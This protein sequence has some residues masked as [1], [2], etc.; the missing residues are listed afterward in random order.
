M[1]CKNPIREMPKKDRIIIGAYG[2][3]NYCTEEHVAAIAESGVDLVLYGLN[4]IPEEHHKDM[5]EWLHKYGIEASMRKGEWMQKYENVPV[6]D[7]EKHGDLWFK[8]EPVFKYFTYVDEPGAV[9]FDMLGEEVEAFKA[10]FP[11]K[12]PFINLLPMYANTKQLSGGSSASPIDYYEYEDAVSAFT[13]YLRAYAEK[14]NTSYICAD[15]YP[16]HRR[17]DPNAPDE[18]PNKYIK[19]TYKDYVKSIE[20]MANVC[21]EFGRDLWVVIQSSSW[22]SGVRVPDE[23]DLRWQAYTML[24]FGAKALLYFVYGGRP[25]KDGGIIA[26]DGSKGE[27]F[28]ASKRLCGGLKKLSDLYLE[29]RN[30]GAF[31]VN[32]DAAKTPY[33]VMENPYSGPV[34]PGEIVTEDSLLIGVFEKKN[35]AGTAFTIVNMNNLQTPKTAHLTLNAPGNVV[36]YRDGV[37]CETAEKGQKLEL[38]LLAGDGVFMTVD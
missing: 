14:V 30:I 15:I 2:P 8:D 35:G 36:V 9:S 32:C 18:F 10:A 38:E 33:L 26:A 20:P 23:A 13:K 19:G 4:Q 21:R 6:L 12:E 28:Y 16:C 11:G 31:N 5:F 34:N 27:L 3:F 22:S 24:S 1:P 29:Y 25:G 37:P 17:P 7:L